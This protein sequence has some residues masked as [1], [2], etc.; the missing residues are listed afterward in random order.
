MEGWGRLY[1]R[2]QKAR[3]QNYGMAFPL[4]ARAAEHWASPACELV[5]GEEGAEFKAQLCRSQTPL[6]MVPC[7]LGDTTYWRHIGSLWCLKMAR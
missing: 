4:A 6:Q 3:G 1:W 5:M 2:G 7:S